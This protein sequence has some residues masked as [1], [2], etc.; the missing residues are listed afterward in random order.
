MDTSI[1]TGPNALFAR[2]TF[3]KG[4]SHTRSCHPESLGLAGYLL[5]CPNNLV[6]H[7]AS[8]FLR[9][10]CRREPLAR[11]LVEL[12]IDLI[13]TRKI[14][15]FARTHGRRCLVADG[16]RNGRRNCLA[17]CLLESGE[18]QM[19]GYMARTSHAT[20]RCP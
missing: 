15:H 9:L 19:G 10:L 18:A 14:F 7:L 20:G 8:G 13:A 5:D 3:T 6:N 12:R 11:Q 1:I 4:A 2:L 17:T 16:Y